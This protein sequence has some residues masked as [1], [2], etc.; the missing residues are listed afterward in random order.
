MTIQKFIDKLQYDQEYAFDK[1]LN[2]ECWI[3]LIADLPDKP[4]LVEKFMLF[5]PDEQL[6][7]FYRFIDGNG[8]KLQWNKVNEKLYDV[9]MEL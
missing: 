6:I 1:C 8:F 2:D 4:G 9:I 3:R 7:E 5:T